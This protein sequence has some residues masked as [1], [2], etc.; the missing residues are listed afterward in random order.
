MIADNENNK[1]TNI[2]NNAI[3][4]ELRVENSNVKNMLEIMDNLGFK[5]KN[6]W[7][8]MNIPNHTVIEFWKK[9]LLKSEGSHDRL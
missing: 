7:A 5:S 6:S 9:D 8:S 3:S 1:L 4:M 2:I